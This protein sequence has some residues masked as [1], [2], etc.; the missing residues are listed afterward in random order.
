MTGT[1]AI[2]VAVAPPRQLTQVAVHHAN[3]HLMMS[4]SQHQKNLFAVHQESRLLHPK[5]DLLTRHP[6]SVLVLAWKPTTT[7]QKY[8]RLSN[9][10]ESISLLRTMK[11]TVQTLLEPTLM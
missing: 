10:T 3:Q 1:E 8:T 6:H 2:A 7:E 11:S 4:L 5:K 9:S